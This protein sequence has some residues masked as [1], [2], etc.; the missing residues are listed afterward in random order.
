VVLTVS[1][2]EDLIFLI[3]H[4][5]GKVNR[6]ERIYL[7][8]DVR[9]MRRIGGDGGGGVDGNLEMAPRLVLPSLFKAPSWT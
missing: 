8:K 2:A 3:R 6:L 9:N 7:G 1:S 4:G 5:R